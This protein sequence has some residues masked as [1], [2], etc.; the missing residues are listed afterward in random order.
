[1]RM[2]TRFNRMIRNRTLWAIFAA[3]VSISF[4]GMFSQTG[5]C[6]GHETRA[7][8]FPEGSLFG[9]DVSRD[10]FYRMRRYALNLGDAAGFSE[11]EEAELRTHIWS[12]LALLR[13]AETLGLD[14]SA[15][16]LGKAIRDM[17]HFAGPDGQFDRNAY[18]S[19]VSSQ[20]RGAPVRLFEENM[21]QAMV[22]QRA[23]HLLDLS[24]WTPPTEVLNDMRDRADRFIV[25]YVLLRPE[26]VGDDPSLT[27]AQAKEFYESR[28]DLFAEPEKVSVR[29]V[30]F[31]VADYLDMTE[32]TDELVE[33]YYRENLSSL[34]TSEGTNGTPVVRSLDDVRESIENELRREAAFRLARKD[35]T[36]LVLALAPSRYSEG[37]SWDEAVG[38]RNLSVATSAFFSVSCD[39]PELSVEPEH[40]R[41]AFG[42]D[43]ESPHRYFSGAIQGGDGMYVL[44][45]HEQ[46]PSYVPEFAEVAEQVMPLAMEQA[47]RDAFAE[48]ANEVA[49]AIRT[50]LAEQTGFSNAVQELD[51]DL[52]PVRTRPF[53][54]HEETMRSFAMTE[55]DDADEAIPYA[56]EIFD[57]LGYVD[58]GDLL[59]P[60]ELK[61]GMLLVRVASREP[62]DPYSLEFM[63]S[64]IRDNLNREKTE[65]LYHEWLRH[66]LALA[67]FVDYEDKRAAEADANARL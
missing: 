46:K 49:V 67:D 51:L 1:M 54:I 39:V 66:M 24:V 16:E 21:R 38:Q 29:Y 26:A 47:R 61:E 52:E 53:S 6:E 15:R 63:R 10:D 33:A 14:V 65:I 32:A 59:D 42:L 19:F 18:R 37:L 58:E 8:S 2:I 20:F 25:E 23:T 28:S 60:I 41:S 50:A 56:R 31:P 7:D 43:A 4:V 22:L 17:P 35:A 12:R 55:E 11:E 48:R 62:G 34:Y 44:A 3:V 27:V 9:E 64:F 40:L 36:D 57:R 5:G 13:H 30:K 45:A